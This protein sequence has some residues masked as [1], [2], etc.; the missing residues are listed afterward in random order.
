MPQIQRLTTRN[1]FSLSV[2]SKIYQSF[3]EPTKNQTC[4]NPAKKYL[5][6]LSIH[7]KMNIWV[8][9]NGFSPLSQLPLPFI[10]LWCGCW[11]GLSYTGPY[12]YPGVGGDGGRSIGGGVGVG[13]V[14][15]KPFPRPG[16]SHTGSSVYSQLTQALGLL[17]YALQQWAQGGNT[18][19]IMIFL[20]IYVKIWNWI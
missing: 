4:V 17:L 9:F 11:K 5:Q 3:C 19:N 15:G 12:S 20:F 7:T 14:E 10:C 18:I 16:L 8:H 13:A 1:N 2:L 6:K